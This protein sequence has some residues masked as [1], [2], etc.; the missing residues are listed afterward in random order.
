MGM[1]SRKQ[2]RIGILDIGVDP[3]VR[4]VGGRLGAMANDLRKR[5]VGGDAKTIGPKRFRQ[6]SGE[7]KFVERQDAALLGFYPED[8]VC[9]AAVRHRE[10]ANGIGPEQ[11][12]WVKHRHDGILR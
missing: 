10:N 3:G 5:L 11:Q 12:V 2:F 7:M 8:L 1:A 6:R 9:S 4:P